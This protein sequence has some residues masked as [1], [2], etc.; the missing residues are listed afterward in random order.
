MIEG[1]Q[2]GEERAL[3]EFLELSKQ[4]CHQKSGVGAVE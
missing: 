1:F 4:R 2:V 3:L